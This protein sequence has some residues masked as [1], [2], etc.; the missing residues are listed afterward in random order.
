MSRASHGFLT[1]ALVI[2]CACERAEPVAP[3]HT[4][5]VTDWGNSVVH[6]IELDGTYAGTFLET[7]ENADAVVKPVLRVK[8]TGL[9]MLSDEPARFWMIAD[10]GVT[11]WDQTGR[12]L[13]EVLFDT[14]ILET[15][16]C[17]VRVGDRVF[18]ASPDKK[19]MQVFDLAGTHLASIG[20]PHLYHANDCK[21]GPDGRIYV[22]STLNRGV[23]GLVS[24]WDPNNVEPDAKP[25]EYRIP[26]DSSGDETYWVHGLVF[27]DDGHLLV[28]EL[29]RGRLERW[30]LKA[31]KRMEVLLDSAEGGAYLELERGPD[32]LVSMAGPAGVYRFDSRAKA[33]DLAGLMPFFDADDIKP[34]TERGFSPS[35]LTFE[36]RSALAPSGPQS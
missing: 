2:T 5:L 16:T 31:N 23:L 24:I 1:L 25:L 30:D 33:A 26:G 28:T 13:R 18:V 20:V 34:P 11:E 21:L 15:P 6:R 3:G 32:G 12:P 27:D 29:S 36:P 7:G 14:Q 19:D 17:A 9:L 22:G 4:L 10:R 35:G 8:P